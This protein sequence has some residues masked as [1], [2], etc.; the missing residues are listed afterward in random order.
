LKKELTIKEFNCRPKENYEVD[1]VNP[2]A[3]KHLVATGKTNIRET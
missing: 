2:I 1:T 3:S